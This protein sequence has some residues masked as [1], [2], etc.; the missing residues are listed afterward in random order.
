LSKKF[1]SLTA[2][3]TSIVPFSPSAS[4]AGFSRIF[5]VPSHVFRTDKHTTE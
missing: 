5:V 3:C 4:I 1:F 2:G